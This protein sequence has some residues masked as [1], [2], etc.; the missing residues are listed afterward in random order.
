MKDMGKTQVWKVNSAINRER[1][2]I[3]QQLGNGLQWARAGVQ[4]QGRV[5]ILV[6]VGGRVVNKYN[7][8][9]EVEAGGG[10]GGFCSFLF[11]RK[12]GE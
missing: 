3:S 5:F 6:L 1:K 11:H 8:L 12:Q 4:T 9:V 7:K 10:G 2:C